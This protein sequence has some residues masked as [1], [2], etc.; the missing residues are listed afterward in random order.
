M[1][2]TEM[3]VSSTVITNT[4][5]NDSLNDISMCSSSSSTG[6]LP[7]SNIA[8]APLSQLQQHQQPLQQPQ[9]S[10]SP[11]IHNTPQRQ[12]LV[13]SNGQIIGNFLV[14]PPPQHH[15]HTQH[16]QNQ[17]QQLLQQAAQQFSFQATQQQQQQNTTVMTAQQQ[18]QQQPNSVA[19]ATRQPTQQ[20]QQLAQ[21][22]LPVIRKSFE[23]SANGQHF[24][25][26]AA[27][28]AAAASQQQQAHIEH[29]QIQQF[30]LQQQQTPQQ[31]PQLAQNLPQQRQF[32]SHSPTQ[33]P[34]SSLTPTNSLITTQH[35]QQLQ[36]QQQLQQLQQQS[37]HL[38]TFQQ[39]VNNQSQ[40]PQQHTQQQ[41]P[42]QQ[43]QLPQTTTITPKFISKQLSIISMPP[44]NATIPSS[45]AAS[46]AVAIPS[47]AATNA[48]YNAN[49]LNATNVSVNVLKTLPPSGVPTTIAQQRAPVKVIAT[50][51]GRKSAANKLPPGAVNIERS[52][53]ICQAVIQNSP[54]RENLKAQLRPP[55]ALLSQQQQQH[56]V[57][58]ATTS[59]KTMITTGVV[60]GGQSPNIVKTPQEDVIINTIAASNTPTANMPT[61]VMG[62][63]RPGVYKVTIKCLYMYV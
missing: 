57:Q 23:M 59:G 10:S 31:Q 61:N 4:N 56:C 55:S 48:L 53:Q 18:Q 27:G 33:Q 16:I 51:K 3:E 32:L 60:T 9:L 5:S 6:S 34:N 52:Y 35:Q 30:S 22:I 36:L 1:S 7:T 8:Q 24:L 58:S 38:N 41:P 45:I 17:Q 42:K 63:G 19:F 29:Q 12:I 47:T 39:N 50:G 49:N 40:Q 26:N 43:P 54:N 2:V 13:D 21:K 20:R 46:T 25:G 15:H 14:Q 44:R 37:H 62:V 28:V 11:T